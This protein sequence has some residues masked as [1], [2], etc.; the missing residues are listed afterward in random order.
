MNPTAARNFSRLIYYL[1]RYSNIFYAIY[2]KNWRRGFINIL[3]L[4]Q[5][6][7]VTR[8]G[9]EVV[10]YNL[11]EEMARRGHY[12]HVISHQIKNLKEN[13]LN[14]MINMHRIKPILENKGGEVPSITQN[15]MYII[16]AILKGSQI[17]RQQKIDI[18]HANQLSPVIA[19]SILAKFHKIP[20]IITIHDVV[21]TSSSYSWKN[22]AAQK[23]VSRASSIIGPFF[24]KITV[25][26]PVDIIHT[27]SN[28]SKEDLVKFNTKASIIRVIPPGIDLRYYDNLGVKK[29]Y[30]SYVLFIGRLVYYK[31]LEILISSFKEITKRLPD[32]KLVAVGDGPM[33][34]KWE[35]MV[36]ELHLDK[37]IEFT[38]FVSHEKKVELLSK[39]SALLFPSSVEGFGLVL[40]EAFAMSKPVLVADVKP[41]DE[42]VDEGIDGF[43][44]PAHNADKWSEKIIFLLLNKRICEI[45]GSK[46]RLK[47]ENKFNIKNVADKVESLYTN[48]WSKKS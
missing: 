12:V 33:R 6:F 8:G 29:E 4:T 42:I 34:D 16:N 40:L 9:G 37:N 1:I 14:G 30:Q 31:N 46:G 43:M 41:F 36:S 10:F 28:A 3:Y 22:W 27:V 35:R 20:I 47:V 15:M 48:M 26:V 21:T 11:A 7:S 39:C 23:N 25:S 19:G 2:V 32:A 38:G 44:L 18:I 13:N 17:I 45:M 5:F 24:E